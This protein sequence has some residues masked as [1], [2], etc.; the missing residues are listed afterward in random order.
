MAAYFVIEVTINHPE[1]Y[2]DYRKLVGP[3]LERYGGTFLVRGGSYETIEGGWQPQRLVIIEFADE[4]Q[5]QRWY[6]SPEYSEA[7]A[8]RF[9]TSTAKAILIQGA[10]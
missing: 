8:I 7:K 5:F 4:Q 3:T 9:K 6:N 1:H 10:V 2:E